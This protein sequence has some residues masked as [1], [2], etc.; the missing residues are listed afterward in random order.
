MFI[1]VS[2]VRLHTYKTQIHQQ[3]DPGLLHIII[4]HTNICFVQLGFEPGMP[5][6]SYE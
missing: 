3:P 1:H 5:A 6:K 4:G 2:W